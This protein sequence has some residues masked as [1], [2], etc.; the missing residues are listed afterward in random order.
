MFGW[1][2]T[3]N[4]ASCARCRKPGAVTVVLDNRIYVMFGYHIQTDVLWDGEDDE[5][6][7]AEMAEMEAQCGKSVSGV[8]PTLYSGMHVC[9][10]NLIHK[11]A[12]TGNG[13]S[14]SVL[15]EESSDTESTSTSNPQ[16]MLT[17]I[18]STFNGY[19][20]IYYTE[21]SQYIDA[22]RHWIHQNPD[23]RRVLSAMACAASEVSSRVEKIALIVQYD[24]RPTHYPT[25]NDSPR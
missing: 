4:F 20:M 3:A 19:R 9:Q 15:R 1:Q 6:L 23:A 10:V 11:P 2:A 25:L 14:T 21:N 17:P 12:V 7:V 13:R 8:M 22:V 24:S 16:A 5:L 18:K